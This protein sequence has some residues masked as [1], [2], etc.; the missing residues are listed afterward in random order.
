MFRSE[1]FVRKNWFEWKNLQRNEKIAYPVHQ[2]YGILFGKL[3]SIILYNFDMNK[4]NGM[5]FRC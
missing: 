5:K 1:L 2:L 3:I 4:I